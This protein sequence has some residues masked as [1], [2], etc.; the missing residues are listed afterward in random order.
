[1]KKTKCAKSAQKYSELEG[2]WQIGSVIVV[3]EQ[4]IVCVHSVDLVSK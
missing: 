3:F 4:L 1:M 2:F